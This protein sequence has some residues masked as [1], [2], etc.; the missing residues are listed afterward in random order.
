MVQITDFADKLKEIR[1]EWDKAESSIK[2]AEQINNQVVFPAVKELRYAGRRIVDALANCATTGDEAAIRALLDDAL[3]DCYRARHDAIDAAVSKVSTHL[4]AVT[5]KLGY[6]AFVDAF[7]DF[8]VLYDELGKA[9]EIIASSRG[10]RSDR[11]KLY[12]AI[13]SVNLPPLVALYRKFKS[14]EPV[15]RGLAQEER[16][17]R[18][19]TIGSAVVLGV[20]ALIVAIWQ[21]VV[22]L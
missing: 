17:L 19:I 6:R 14:S 15:M 2:I 20:A 1:A 18:A 11:D 8:A 22:S 12:T 5:G 16:R 4:D 9:Q 13:E 7:P 21:L 10:M 3:F